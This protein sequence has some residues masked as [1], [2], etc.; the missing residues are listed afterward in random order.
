[1]GAR[2]FS[3]VS[4][5][6]A[7]ANYPANDFALFHALLYTKTKGLVGGAQRYGVT[8]RPCCSAV[9]RVAMYFSI[10][11]AA[12]W[13]RARTWTGLAHGLGGAGDARVCAPGAQS[14]AAAQPHMRD[15]PSDL[16]AHPSP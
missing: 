1:V 10:A 12:R 4:A 14:A 16:V 9:W 13:A 15:V 6:G 3:L 5:Q 7:N 8:S 2:Q 11:N